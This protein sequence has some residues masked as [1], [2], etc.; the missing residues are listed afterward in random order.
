MNI[1]QVLS[2]IFVGIIGLF[3]FLLVIVTIG[4]LIDD[5]N[6]DIW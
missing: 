3:I 2:L 1:L 4:L 5:K 6:E